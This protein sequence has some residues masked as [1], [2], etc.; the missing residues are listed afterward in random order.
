MTDELPRLLTKTEVRHALG[1]SERQVEHIFRALPVV[2][3]PGSSRLYVRMDHVTGMLR[4]HT[5]ED[6]A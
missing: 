6:A 3:L 1:V 2:Q 5:F 4:N